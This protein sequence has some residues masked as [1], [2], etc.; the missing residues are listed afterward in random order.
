M[1]ELRGLARRADLTD[2]PWALLAPCIPG[3]PRQAAGRGR[4][5]QPDDRAVRH[6][7]LWALR[8]GAAWADLPERFPSGAT[9][10][11]RCSRWV[12]AGGLRQ[13]LE[14]RARA[15]EARGQSDLAV[16]AIAGTCVVAKQGVPRWVRPSGA[17][18]RSSC[19]MTGKRVS[20]LMGK[21]GL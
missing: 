8:P 6:G 13:L 15:L 18:G 21:H 5:L 9:G 19:G 2:A 16:C 7:G 17:K 20:G 10:F 12:N 14:T 3:Q 1:G 4:P 11:R